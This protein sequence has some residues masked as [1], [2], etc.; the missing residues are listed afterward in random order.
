MKRIIF[1]ALMLAP[2]AIVIAVPL[3]LVF[4]TNVP[5]LLYIQSI[6][7]IPFDCMRIVDADYVYAMKPG[8]CRLTNIEFD[9][10]QTH[11]K[12]GFRN[13]TSEENSAVVVIGDSHAYGWGV[14]DTQTFS[15][16]LASAYGYRTRNLA[17]PSYATARE[18]ATL[19][20][21][22]ASAKYVVLQYCD[23]DAAENEAS[24][25]LSSVGMHAMIATE[26]KHLVASYHEGKA[27]GLRKPLADLAT[28]LKDGAFATHLPWRRN[29]P[30]RDMNAEASV[31]ARL[32]ARYRPALEGR[33]LIVLESVNFGF[34]TPEFGAAF[35]RAL[36]EL[37]WLEARVINSAAIVDASD[38][39]FLDDHLRPSGHAKLAAAIA[40]EIA[41][42]EKTGARLTGP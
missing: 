16:L 24:L 38:Y 20:A 4:F 26:W 35:G 29:P 12:D 19:A 39:Y 3:Y 2:L 42:W 17:V 8:S 22:G 30:L 1:G 14:G 13:S 37:G 23:N 34:N 25:V 18:L 40:A 31:F 41:A 32:V 28:M 7:D 36:G 21:H 11:D 33:R 9:T 10:V 5:Q 6:R 15:Y 27:Q